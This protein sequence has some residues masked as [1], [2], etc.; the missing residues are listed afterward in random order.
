[1]PAAIADF[2]ALVASDCLNVHFPRAM[3]EIP[4][5]RRH[6]VPGCLMRCQREAQRRR[7]VAWRYE[8]GI[9]VAV[10]SKVCA[11]SFSAISSFS[12]RSST[13][14]RAVIDIERDGTGPIVLRFRI[15]SA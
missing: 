12:N 2:I 8:S 7:C 4:A 6:S 11:V 9:S 1:K 10:Q 13:L 3:R 14:V 5:F 15:D